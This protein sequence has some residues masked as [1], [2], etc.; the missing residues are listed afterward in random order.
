MIPYNRSSFF[1]VQISSSKHFMD[2]FTTS[3]RH[4]EQQATSGNTEPAEWEKHFSIQFVF[5]YSPNITHLE[6]AVTKIYTRLA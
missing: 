5:E 3:E 4:T 2:S 1:T 6:G